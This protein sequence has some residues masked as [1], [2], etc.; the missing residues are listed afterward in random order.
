MATP[1]SSTR[2]PRAD[3]LPEGIVDAL[4]RALGAALVARFMLDRPAA[5]E[6]RVA[7]PRGRAH[8]R[9]VRLDATPWMADGQHGPMDGSRK[10]RAL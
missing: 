2:A 7:S 5:V 6:T 8:L 9:V 1:A 3:A 10:S 4:A